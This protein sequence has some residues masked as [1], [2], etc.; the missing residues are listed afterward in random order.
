MQGDQFCVSPS[1]NDREGPLILDREHGF[2]WTRD[3]GVPTAAL[4]RRVKFALDSDSGRLLIWREQKHHIP[5]INTVENHKLPR[6]WNNGSG[7]GNL[8]LWSH[9]D[10]HVYWRNCEKA[11]LRYQDEISGDPY[12]CPYADAISI[13]SFLMDDNANTKLR[14][15]LRNI[16]RVLVWS[17]W[18]C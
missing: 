7:R 6:W 13:F 18:N 3:S 9:F 15:C 5:S 14:I 16:L 2:T 8:T 12:V 17:E 11:G 10:L 4:Y 1:T